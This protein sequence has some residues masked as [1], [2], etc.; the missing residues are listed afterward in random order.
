MAAIATARPLGHPL[1]QGRWGRDRGCRLK[2]DHAGSG[3]LCLT[4]TLTLTL[5]T[6]PNPNAGSGPL[7]CCQRRHQPRGSAPQPVAHTGD[8][9]GAAGAASG[10][11]ISGPSPEKARAT[12]DRGAAHPL[13][14]A[15]PKGHQTTAT[16][17]PSPYL[18]PPPIQPTLP[19][20]SQNLGFDMRLLRLGLRHKKMKTDL[21]SLGGSSTGARP[22]GARR[23]DKPISEHLLW[24]SM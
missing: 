16:P 21:A 18:P 11:Q 5:T 7:R 4:L 17:T 15:Q 22:R 3:P 14:S 6:D 1:S 20:H 24:R 23:L 2:R 8:P 9:A 19:P 13:R 12:S 10:E